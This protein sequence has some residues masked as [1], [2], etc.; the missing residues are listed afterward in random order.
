MES[1]NLG[2]VASSVGLS[3]YVIGYGLGP[4]IM[5]PLSEVPWTGRNPPYLIGKFIFVILCIPIALVDNFAGMLVLRF[6]LGVAGSP[7]LAT[8]GA[9]YG[10]FA[11]GMQLPY[12]IAIWAGGAS[13][14]PVRTSV[15]NASICT[16]LIHVQSLGPLISNF[17]VTASWR[18][19]FYETLLIAGPTFFVMLF[20]LPETSGDYILLRRAQR[21]RKLTGRSDLMAESEIKAR[22]QKP[23]E[24]LFQAL[25]KPWEI[26]MKDPAV[27]FTTLYLG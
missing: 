11:T 5:S 14:G 19:P 6:L 1:W 10:D 8:G 7:A 2:R 12:A 24:V 20:L 15:F 26:N 27:L 3:I 9:S 23:K 21:L 22:D 18:W 13:A 16:I 17:A 4:L 25:I